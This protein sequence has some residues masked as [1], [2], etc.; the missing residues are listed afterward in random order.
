M[1]MIIKQLFIFLIFNI[2][3]THQERLTPLS[4]CKKGR[5]A[6]YTGWEKG[7]QCGFGPH[8]N[9]TSSSYLYPVSPNFDLFNSYSHCGTC[10]EIVGPYGAIRV[11]VEDYCK[12]NDELG[13]CEGDMY[14][15]NVANNGSSFLMGDNELSNVTFRMV[16]CGL[17]GNVRIL[18][19]D[20]FD[21]YSFS[22]I[23]LDHNLPISY[24]TINEYST[25][26]WTKAIRNNNNNHW[27]YEVNFKILFPLTIRIYSINDDYVTVKIQ[28]LKAGQIYE[29]NENFKM[30]DNTYF[31][32]NTFDKEEKPDN[33]EEC[34]ER[35]K[36]D[37]NP[38]Y[39][40][41]IFNEGYYNYNQKVT[42]DDKS[43]ELY[44]DQP[45]MSIVFQSLGEFII[46]PAFPI[47]ADQFSGVSLTIKTKSIC[48]DCLNLRAYDLKNK[49]QVLK[50]DTENEWKV[51]RFSF[52][53]LGIENNEFNGFAIK[54][55]KAKSQSYEINIG[56]I[57]LLGVRNPPKAGVCVDVNNIV[58]PPVISPT[59]EETTKTD[60]PENNNPNE[61]KTDSNIE[62][63]NNTVS[64]NVNIISIES[65]DD[66][67]LILNIQ[68]EPFEEINNEKMVLLFTSKDDSNTFETESCILPT[69]GPISSFSCKLP[70]YVPNGVYTIKSPS[71]N[72]YIIHYSNIVSIPDGYI[73]FIPTDTT[74]EESGQKQNN[75]VEEKSPIIITN[76]IDEVVNRGDLITFQI[77]PIMPSEYSLQN[78]EIILIDSTKTKFLY[79]KYC[80]EILNDNQIT[81]IN[82][83]V[84][85]NIMKGNYNTLAEDQNIEILS[86]KRIYLRSLITT[87]GFFT[88]TISININ[89]TLT[90]AEKKNFYLTFNI[91]YYNS[92]LKPGDLFPYR[93]YLYGIKSSNS[94]KRSLELNNYDTKI[95]FPKCTA[96]NYSLEDKNAI[97]SINCLAPDY[98]PAGTY[99]KLE[100]DGFDM[101]PNSHLNLVFQND[102]QRANS[103]SQISQVDNQQKKTK[104]KSKTWI[105]WVVFG[106]IIIV[107][108]VIVLCICIANK[109]GPGNSMN[110]TE[111]KENSNTNITQDSKQSK[112]DVSQND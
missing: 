66:I 29:A 15:F 85:N 107:L 78:K 18:M 5:I 62:E 93:V 44:Q 13:Y 55:S 27:K 84:S 101:T 37:F 11:R 8:K 83:T 100:S 25:T 48:T 4:E 75:T 90:E 89:N 10:Y 74:I 61:V 49:N 7:G 94:G 47:R 73:N 16:S 110:E 20:N 35:D 1:K 21:E 59:N 14:H 76:S 97:G 19:D 87:G 98:I 82:C 32:I 72:K 105:I 108:A 17:A 91:L 79:L 77:S 112:S 45:S 6:P 53:T 46:R 70:N 58:V 63:G 52:D 88:E 40:N 24:V 26:T 43:N 31:D 102:F 67:P 95:L 60:V 38:I 106:I 103:N 2:A 71:D 22:F 34:C 80:R 56:N 68:C 111:N 33:A 99:S 54:Y 81:S 65:R 69:P 57:E 28:S 86:G 104:S 96:G 3:L 51:Y 109:K 30:P 39:K 41:G 64:R 42:V 23:V 9:A 12:K 92:T 36:S 50:L